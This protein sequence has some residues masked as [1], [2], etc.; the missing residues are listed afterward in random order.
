LPISLGYPRDCAE[1]YLGGNTS[2]T[3][4]LIYPWGNR[5]QSA[6]VYCENGYTYLLKRGDINVNYLS[7]R[8]DFSRNWTEYENGFG[9]F[10]GDSWLGKFEKMDPNAY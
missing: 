10:C 5:N 1:V 7:Q 8:E 9:Q 2:N 3:V 4:Y 6:K